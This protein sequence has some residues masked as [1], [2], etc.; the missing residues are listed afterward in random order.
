MQLLHAPLFDGILFGSRVRNRMA[1]LAEQVASGY[2]GAAEPGI[3]VVVRTL[4]EATGLR[5]LLEDIAKQDYSGPVEVIVVDNESVDGTLAVAREFGATVVTLPRSDFT[6]PRSMNLGVQAATHDIVWL[7]VGHALPVSR[8][9]LRSGARW[10]SDAKV[11]GVFMP[12]IFPNSNG[13]AFEKLFPLA[14]LV[15]FRRP[16]Q[17]KKSGLGVMGATSA[18]IS[19]KAWQQLG[20]FDERYETGGEDTALAAK[21]LQA[22][23]KIVREP[24]MAVHHSHGVSLGAALKQH[25]HYMRTVKGPVPMKERA[26]T[27]THINFDT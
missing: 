11:S 20:R 1:A 5:Q 6:Y 4:N 21:M 9:L 27:P 18:M 8:Q 23:Y 25:R 7:S 22:G 17:I 15:A 14:S 13:S 10:F 3:S 24:A 26:K 2:D 12:P 16:K 19:K